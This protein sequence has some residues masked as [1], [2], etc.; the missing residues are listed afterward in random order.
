[1]TK[2]ALSIINTSLQNLNIEYSFGS[3]S[4][5]P[6]VYPYF[7]GEYTEVEVLSEDGLQETTFMITG[8]SRS[9][10]MDLETV[11]DKI[12]NFF[13]PNGK[14]FMAA[15]GSGIVIMYTNTIMVPKED[16]ELKS[17]QINLTIKEWK[18]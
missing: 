11:K 8:F 14:T 13:D 17:I 10:W 9:S 2:N 12:A 18:V 6:I 15:D 7:V 1:M 3:Y 5:N 4:K 16:P